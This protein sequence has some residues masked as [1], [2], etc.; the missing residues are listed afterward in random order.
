MLSLSLKQI[1]C[2]L[3][4]QLIPQ[5][6]FQT[7][8]TINYLV[9]SIYIVQLFAHIFLSCEFEFIWLSLSEKK[10][11]KYFKK[12]QLATVNMTTKINSVK[13]FSYV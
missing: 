3:L 11:K 12:K 5:K 7:I 8:I 4:K 2:S 6:Q 9:K 10:L 13:N 1:K